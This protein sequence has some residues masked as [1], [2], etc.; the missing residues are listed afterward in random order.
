[1]GKKPARTIKSDVIDDLLKIESHEDII[2]YKKVEAKMC[3]AA[4][5]DDALLKNRMSKIEFA[6]KMNQLPSVIT[7]WLSGT[8]NFTVE[9]LI[10]IEEVLKINLL[11]YKK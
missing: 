9:T 11:K 3:I 10:E 1:M 6:T 2:S 8:H 7:K 5:I 4:R